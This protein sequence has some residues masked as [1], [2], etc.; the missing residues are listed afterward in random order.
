MLSIARISDASLTSAENFLDEARTFSSLCTVESDDLSR[1]VYGLLGLPV[2]AVNFTV[3]SRS[4]DSVTRHPAPFLISTANV[5]FLVKSLT[6]EAFR[7]SVLSSD[8]S[9]AD[10][11][12]LIWMAKLLRV[13]IHERVAG[14]DLFVRLKLVGA[15][16]RCLKVF[17]LGG[18]PGLAEK[19]SE[20]LNAEPCGLQCV[21]V[22][23]PGFGTI[24]EMSGDAV[25]EAINS[26]GADLLAVFFSAER[27]QQWL[28]HNHWRLKPPVRAQFGATINFEAGTVKRAP[29][30]L[31]ST[32]FEWLWRIKEEPHLW[33]RYWS[34]GRALLKLLATSVI[35]LAVVARRRERESRF[36]TIQRD[37]ESSSVT[38]RLSGSATSGYVDL[39]AGHF[40]AALAAEKHVKLCLKDAT[41]IDPRFF[42][43]LLMLRKSLARLG[44]RLVVTGVS[45]R[46]RRM[47]Q[48][49]RFEY[50]LES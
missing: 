4:M 9:L 24:E 19:V 39:A 38:L 45:S 6:N 13:P 15:A 48:L 3:L 44:K 30:F 12:P 25:I 40:R 11:M 20:R 47:F 43:L 22:L 21:G 18:T 42:G 27:A 8:L 50:L 41:T 31:R 26:S 2:D 32:G 28:M 46:L 16:G 10:G 23:N 14:A 29:A 1:P 36:L 7:E 34:D 33:R 49:N 37:D 17:L 35:P 5:N